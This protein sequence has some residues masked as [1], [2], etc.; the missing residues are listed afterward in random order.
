MQAIMKVEF[1]KLV[2]LKVELIIKTKIYP[3]RK[4]HIK[5]VIQNKK[6]NKN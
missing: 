5:E 6:G 2:F 1:N 3:L 4:I